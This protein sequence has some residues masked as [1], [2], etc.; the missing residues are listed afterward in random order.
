MDA[1]WEDG[2][3][4]LVTTTAGWID[5][6]STY[7]GLD[8]VSTAVPVALIQG[9]PYYKHHGFNRMRLFK[10]GGRFKPR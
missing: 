2:M 6:K 3:T 7:L 4:K 9:Q 5:G 8:R 10:Y 1:R